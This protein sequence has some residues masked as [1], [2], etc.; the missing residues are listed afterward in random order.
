MAG[1]PSRLRWFIF[2]SGALSLLVLRDLLLPIAAG[3]SFAY[4]SE[5]PLE[6][7]ARRLRRV[8][9]ERFRR[10]SSVGFVALAF[11]LV[12]VPIGASAV[13]AARG[14][15]SVL[16]RGNVELATSWGRKVLSAAGQRLSSLEL[17]VRTDELSGKMTEL[18]TAGVS[19]VGGQLGSVVT[20]T[21]MALLE[22]SLFV[23]S[24]IYFAAEG[25]GLRGRVLPVLLPWEKPR[26][27]ICRATAEVLEG[28]VVANGLVS[29]VQAA[30]CSL[31]LLIASVPQALV[32]GSLSFFFSFVPVVGTA[33]I[34]LGAAA[35][36]YAQGRPGWAVFMV[37]V[38]VVVGTV[39]NLLRPLF[40]QSSSRLGFTWLF[41]GLLGGLSAFG[42][43]GVVLGPLALT[44]FTEFV[45]E[46]IQENQQQSEQ[47]AANNDDSHQ[48]PP[49]Q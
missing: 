28:V 44:L 16:S 34:T 27:I 5:R 18:L 11:H 6:W 42:V 4:V 21:P 31:S 22:A 43:A 25:R 10:W 23:L 39:D 30:I 13:V 47:I 15:S 14:V 2:A 24:W 7:L 40:M 3:A 37:V 48:E 12:V 36:C 26:E 20:A 1:Q 17:P 9:D 46:W 32:W 45:E 38:A 33:P 8:D 35:Y 29:A 19:A 49:T 41:A